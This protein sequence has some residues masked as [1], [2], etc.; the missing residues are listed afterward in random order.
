MKVKFAVVLAVVFLIAFEAPRLFAEDGRFALSAKA[1]TL[2][3]GLEAAANLNSNFNA[4][5]G[6]NIFEYDYDG[7]ES[8][9]KYDFELGLLT[10]AGLVDW[11]PFEQGFRLTGGLMVNNNDLDMKATASGSYDIGG[12][13][14]TAAEVGTLKGELDFND[15]APYIGLGWGNPFG[16]ESN[17]SFNFDLG[18]MFQGSP[19]VSFST[20]GT[21][22]NNAAFRTNLERE[23]QD[24]EG[25]LDDFEY[26]PVISFG[27]TYRF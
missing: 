4:R 9:I 11:F 20:D 17:W 2:G 1:G 13:T 18:V 23:K 12:T 16:R 14:Y 26:Y 21:L 7:T 5:L 8:N 3:I 24:L 15:F 6:F 19:D 25:E 22:S 10:F 27:V